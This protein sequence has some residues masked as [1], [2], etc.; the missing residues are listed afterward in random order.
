[1]KDSSIN[2]EKSHVCVPRKIDFVYRGKLVFDDANVCSHVADISGCIA[3]AYS[4]ELDVLLS[5]EIRFQIWCAIMPG[6]KVG[7]P[8]IFLVC[9][10]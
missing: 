1:M 7:Q 3:H 6:N 4:I 2:K 9:F 5:L 10:F 8:K